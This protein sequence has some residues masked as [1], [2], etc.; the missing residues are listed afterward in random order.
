MNEVEQEAAQNSAEE[1]SIDLVSI[2]STHFNKNGSILTA[3][4]KTSAGPNNMM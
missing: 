1:N 2:N 4:L 3:I